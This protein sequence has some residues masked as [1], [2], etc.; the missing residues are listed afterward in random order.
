MR[1]DGFDRRS[2]LTATTALGA[3]G[4]LPRGALAQAAA[5]ASRPAA[6]LPARGEFVVRG[7]HVLSMDDKIGDL[8]GGDVHVRDGAIVAVAASVNAPGAQVIDGKGMICMPGF[9]DTHWHHW[10]TFLRPLMRAD[11]PKRTYFPVTFAVG[12]H[13]TPEDSYRA[14]RLGLA[15]ALSAG[16]T[17]THNWAHNVRSPAH[18]DA[19]V[20]AMRDAGMRG[21]FAYGPPSA[22]RTTSRWISPTG[23]GSSATSARTT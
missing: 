20:Q 3:A 6:A 11:D 2:V 19:E 7:A 22:C 1:K 12:L 18:A 8:P 15:E 9:V 21:R 16:V 5:P 17:T 10:T 4:L 13:Y 23:R 14:V